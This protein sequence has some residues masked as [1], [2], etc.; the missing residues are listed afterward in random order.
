MKNEY[1][2]KLSSDRFFRVNAVN[3]DEAQDKIDNCDDITEF[4]IYDR[5]VIQPEFELI[6][7]HEVK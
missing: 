4:E 5:D 3:S 6:E 1:I 2:F 7:K